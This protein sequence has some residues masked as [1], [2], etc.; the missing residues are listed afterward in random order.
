MN[1]QSVSVSQTDMR[2]LL[3]A[4]S[5]DA[6]LLY[7]YIEA[8]NDPG[9]AEEDLKLTPSRISFATALL[10]Q[11]GLWSDE[12]RMPVMPGERPQYTEADVTEAM[13]DDDSFQALYEEV[14]RLLGKVL[15]HEELKILL[16]FERYLGLPADVISVLICYC[17]D[18]ARRQGRTRMPSL[19]TIEKEAYVWAEMG[20]DTLEDA[21]AYIQKQNVRST[22]LYRIME[23]LQIRGRSLTPGENKYAESWMDMG[24]DD[25]AIQ[26]A[27]ERTCL[28]TGSLKWSYMDKILNRWHAAGLHTGEQIA[29]GDRKPDAKAPGERQLDADEQAAI[30]RMLR[31]G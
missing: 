14:Q 9:Q 22:R 4:A 3:S 27:Y 8:G 19:R 11:M 30:A 6:A 20:I 31:E 26:E 28:N 25:A 24:F 1:I 17:K 5:P 16:G 2:K 23:I 7:L 21:A 12:K 15:N 29:S 13:S 18:R 10:R